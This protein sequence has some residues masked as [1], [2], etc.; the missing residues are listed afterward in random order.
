MHLY[1]VF[2]HIN[3]SE[4]NIITQKHDNNISCVSSLRFQLVGCTTEILAVSVMIVNIQSTV[5]DYIIVLSVIVITKVF[6]MFVI[7]CHTARGHHDAWR[8]MGLVL[9]FK[10]FIFFRLMTIILKIF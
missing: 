4:E 1:L 7:V 5:I 6:H 3:Y 8:Y 9:D 2:V 10:H